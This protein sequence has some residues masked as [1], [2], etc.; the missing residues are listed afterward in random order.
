MLILTLVNSV[1]VDVRSEFMGWAVV[2]N[3][4]KL[5]LIESGVLQV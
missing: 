2:K 1:I 5:Y 3:Q 4:F